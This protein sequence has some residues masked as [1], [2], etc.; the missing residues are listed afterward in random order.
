VALT[1]SRGF[2]DT[3]IQIQK[4]NAADKLIQNDI[5]S[6]MRNLSFEQSILPF[7]MN[8]G[9]VQ[10]TLHAM[11]AHSDYAELQENGCDLLW[12]L[13]SFSSEAKIQICSDGGLQCIVK[14][15]LFSLKFSTRLFDRF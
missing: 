13:S 3:L 5:I 7:I 10:S 15:I 12:K 14:V 9:F 4:V 1:A 2:F 8:R 11:E 6:L